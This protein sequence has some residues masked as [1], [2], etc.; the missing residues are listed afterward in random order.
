MIKVSWPQGNRAPVSLRVPASKSELNRM[1]ILAALRE[2]RTRISGV[3]RCDDVRHMVD[4]LMSLGVRIDEDA[5]GYVVQKGA[6]GMLF[7][8]DCV[9]CGSAGTTF[10]FL[11]A[12]VAQLDGVTELEAD[13]QLLARPQRELMQFL[14]DVGAQVE[15]KS[16]GLRI[17]GNPHWPSALSTSAERSSQFASSVLLSATALAH[18]LTL[19]LDDPPVS[20][21]YLDLT[22]ELIA[23]S[24]AEV[25][26]EG[27]NI[28]ITPCHLDIQKSEQAW[29]AEGDASS[30]AVWM[31]AHVLG[32]PV[33]VENYPESPLQADTQL[34]AMLDHFGSQP[35]HGDKRGFNLGDAPDLAP[36][37]AVLSA[38]LPGQTTVVGAEQ[39]RHKESNRIEQM[40]SSYASVGI[41]IEARPDGFFIEGGQT[42][43]PGTIDPAGDH[44]LAMAAT[45]LAART[46][47]VQISNSSVVSKSYPEFWD[48]AEA[49]GWKIE[50]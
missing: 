43:K 7:P 40:V 36:V 15:E 6:L 9:Y 17:R 39:L 44:R 16:H 14:E 31:A 10:R 45:L 5:N 38:L 48:Q 34:R 23:S 50:R 3:S 27:E 22:L 28:L 49:I 21:P 47:S 25:K 1:L 18:P 41:Q 46:D 42:P 37:L 24:G 11:A 19:H 29:I 8:S 33:E 30:A 13:P 4:G 35:S 12:L 26:R 32:W 20:R 2:G